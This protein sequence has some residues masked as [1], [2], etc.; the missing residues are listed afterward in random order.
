MLSAGAYGFQISS[1]G[2]TADGRERI[3]LVSPSDVANKLASMEQEIER[4]KN[5]QKTTL[6]QF[7]HL[8][9]KS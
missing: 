7:A 9:N 6:S 4:L 8:T 5:L 2:K 1:L 3:L